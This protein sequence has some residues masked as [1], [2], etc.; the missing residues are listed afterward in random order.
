MDVTGSPSTK[1]EYEASIF[2]SN[3]PNSTGEK[4]PGFIS[5]PI[6]TYNNTKQK[7]RLSA[8]GIVQFVGFF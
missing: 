5:T 4:S 2:F 8:C 7:E 3:F 1:V 6:L